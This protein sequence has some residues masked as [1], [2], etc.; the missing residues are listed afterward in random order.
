MRVLFMM[1]FMALFALPLAARDGGDPMQI[2]VHANGNTTRF[3]L[4]DSPASKALYDQLPLSIEV[5]DYGSNEKIFYP[6]KK[7]ATEDTPPADA[8]AGTLA[9]YAPWGDVVMFYRAFGKASGL[10]ELGHA[11]EGGEHIQTMS[12]VITVEAVE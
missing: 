5:E 11:L 10:Y 2:S 7:L 3:Q 12:G 6:P 4:N 1:I 9:Y 8:K